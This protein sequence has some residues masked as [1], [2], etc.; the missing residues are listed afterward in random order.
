MVQVGTWRYGLSWDIDIWFRLG[1]RDMVQVGTQ[2]YGLGLGH[3]D[4]VQVGTQRYGLGWDIE[5]WFRFGTQ[6]YGKITDSYAKI[7]KFVCQSVK[8]NEKNH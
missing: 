3:R 5:I 2:R 4:M 1:R 6:R 8:K 7:I